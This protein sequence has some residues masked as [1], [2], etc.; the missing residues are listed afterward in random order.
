MKSETDTID[1]ITFDGITVQITQ[2]LHMFLNVLPMVM[3]VLEH[4][5][6]GDIGDREA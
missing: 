4:M 5:I 1:W 2:L 3:I 6:W